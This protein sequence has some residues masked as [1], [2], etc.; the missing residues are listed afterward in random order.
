MFTLF[1]LMMMALFGALV[2]GITGDGGDGADEGATDTVTDVA[3][4]EPAEVT[5]WG[6][7]IEQNAPLN[8]SADAPAAADAEPGAADVETAAE[9]DPPAEV[10]VAALQAR[11][12]ELEPVGGWAASVQQLAALG[13]T[14]EQFSERIAAVQSGQQLQQP[15]TE[16]DAFAEWAATEGLDLDECTPA[17][18]RSLL[19]TYRQEQ[20]MAAQQEQYQQARQEAEQAQLT[21]RWTTDLAHLSTEFPE[22]GNPVLR[23]ALLNT[24]EGRYGVQPNAEQLGQLATELRGAIQGITRAE[25]AKYATN[26]QADAAVPVLGGGNAPAPVKTVD[27][28]NLSATK[29]QELLESHVSASLA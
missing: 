26:K 23:D 8:A 12:A 9:V 6:T 14:P 19:G 13:I 11:L 17:E 18:R 27:F 22:F 24:Y 2:L 15:A 7:W 20:F 10:D 21:A 3:G 29:Q 5:D 4:G 28:H 1:G 16:A 25:V